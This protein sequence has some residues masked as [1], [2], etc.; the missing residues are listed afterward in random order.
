MINI[1]FQR[2]TF[3]RAKYCVNVEHVVIPTYTSNPAQSLLNLPGMRRVNYYVKHLIQVHVHVLA[4][5]LII[6]FSLLFLLL[7]LWLWLSS[8]SYPLPLL[9]NPNSTVKH[10]F[11][12]LLSIA[13]A[14][15]TTGTLAQGW[16]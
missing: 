14:K 5:F 13:N 7:F 9:D 8:L 15:S 2:V 12:P 4:V 3:L 1:V 6:F 10:W 11:L 16:A